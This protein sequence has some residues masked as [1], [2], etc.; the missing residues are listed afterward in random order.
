V[1]AYVLI[2]GYPPFYHADESTLFKLISNGTFSFDPKYWSGVSGECKDF[3]K[4]M[5][6]VDVKARW[7][8]DQLL[9]HPWMLSAEYNGKPS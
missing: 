2:C 4:K 6:V 3:I 9:A 8:A 7:T 1:T 5:L